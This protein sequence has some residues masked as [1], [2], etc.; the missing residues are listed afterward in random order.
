MFFLASKLFWAIFEPSHLL[1]FAVI[2]TAILL[3]TRHAVLGRYFAIGSAALFVVIGFFPLGIWLLRPLEDR[4]SRPNWPPHV[5]G[6]L[7]LG[8]GAH[9]EILDSRG[10]PAVEFSDRRLIGA[11]ELARRYPNARIVFSGGSGEVGGAA[12]SETRG[13]QYVFRQLGLDP[14]RLMLEGH[15]RNT[16]ENFVFSR[17]LAEPGPKETWLLAMSAYQMPR[18]MLVA[19]RTHWR[20]VA[21]PTDY[22]TP[23]DG[24]VGA[25]N[26]PRNLQLFDLAVHEWIGLLAYT[27]K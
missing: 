19:R 8:G 14:R 11:F 9:P 24:L 7:V 26:V 4:Y 20:M 1:G 15:S 5:D 10:V 16:W 2:A 18:A 3:Q 17:S 13:A 25:M 27:L 12:F 23:S 21:W 6:V 22:M